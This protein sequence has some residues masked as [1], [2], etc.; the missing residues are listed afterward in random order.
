[1]RSIQLDGVS[2]NLKRV[3]DSVTG[4]VNFPAPFKRSPVERSTFAPHAVAISA[5]L[6]GA[7]LSAARKT[8]AIAAYGRRI[9]HDQAATRGE[10]AAIAS[11]GGYV[12]PISR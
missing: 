6:P 8:E 9:R 5:T 11:H 12:R 1:M 3:G 10:I 4:F 2:V 7:R